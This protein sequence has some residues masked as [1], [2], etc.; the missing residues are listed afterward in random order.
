MAEQRDGT[1]RTG[2]MMA[3]SNSPTPELDWH[4]TSFEG[5]RREQSG[6]WAQLPLETI[7]VA[8]EEMQDIAQQL[9]AM[10]TGMCGESGT[11]SQCKRAA[12]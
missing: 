8:I 5:A 10:P 3:E 7:L 4:L 11:G 12:G 1:M 6:R 2:R 9:G